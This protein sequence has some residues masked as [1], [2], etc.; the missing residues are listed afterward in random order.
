MLREGIPLQDTLLRV[1]ACTPG[2]QSNLS[3]PDKISPGINPGANFSLP[4]NVHGESH[5]AL[6]QEV[7]KAY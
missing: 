6:E 5:S 3:P 7:K 2:V 4:P 1:E